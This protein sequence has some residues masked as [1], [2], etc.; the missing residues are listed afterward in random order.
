MTKNKFV[1][2]EEWGEARAGDIN[3]IRLGVMLDTKQAIVS[4]HSWFLAR[5]HQPLGGR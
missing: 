2:T 1:W 4:R 3:L 5:L